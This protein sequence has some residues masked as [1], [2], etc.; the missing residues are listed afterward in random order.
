[1]TKLEIAEISPFFIVHNLA[2]ALSFYR[3]RLGF[4]VTFEGPADDP[5][6]GIVRRGG[7]MIM[8]KDLGVDPVPNYRRDPAFSWDAYV[9]VPDP[10]ALAAEFA[11]RN[12]DFAEP[13]KDND[14]GLRGFVVKDPDGYG[15][16][17][18]CLRSP[19]RT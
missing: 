19:V 2:R 8:F 14:D 11:S 16:Y 10:D 13:L 15:L 1:M 6:F 7:A 12:V 5:F 17:F 9:D 3:D 18:G 4:E